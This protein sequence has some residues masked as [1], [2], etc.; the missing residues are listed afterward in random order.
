[1]KNSVGT[2]NQTLDKMRGGKPLNERSCKV[3]AG[4]L[5]ELGNFSD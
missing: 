1:M 3:I 2:K 5:Q 4:E